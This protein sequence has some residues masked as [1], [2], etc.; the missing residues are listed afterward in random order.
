MFHQKTLPVPSSLVS[1]EVMMEISCVIPD[2]CYATK[3]VY[4]ILTSD[5]GDNILKHP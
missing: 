1:I 2:Q 3:D 4:K 5:K